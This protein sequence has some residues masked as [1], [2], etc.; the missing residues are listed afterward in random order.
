MAIV[1]YRAKRKITGGRYISSRTKKLYEM[2][3]N[4]TLPNIAERKCKKIKTKGGNLKF[5]I[6]SAQIVNVIDP[7]TKR[8]MQAT[9]KYVGDNPANRHYVRMNAL[10]RGAIV[11]TDKGKVRI[12]SRPAQDGCVNGML[13]K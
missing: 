13:I 3:N 9:M 4:P 1:Q 10:T 12:T 2:G 11:E 6:L 8:A 5:R 7:A